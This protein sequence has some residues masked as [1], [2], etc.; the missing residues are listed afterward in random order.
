MMLLP[1]TVAVQEPSVLITPDFRMAF[2]WSLIVRTYTSN[3]VAI[4]NAVIRT[5]PDCGTDTNPFS[6]VIAS[7]FINLFFL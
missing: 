5:S 1:V 6:M 2:A 7:L 3:K 4:S